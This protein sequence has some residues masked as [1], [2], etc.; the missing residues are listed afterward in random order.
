MAVALLLHVLGVVVWVGGMFFALVALRP[1]AMA[2]LQPPQLLPL[3]A[4]T[5][6][7]FLSWVAGTIIVI[8]G[9]GFYMIAA[10]GGFR[11]VGTHVHVMLAM[12]IL[13]ML[14]FVHIRVAPFRRLAGAVVSQSWPRAGAAMASIRKYIAVNLGL[15]LLTIAIAILGRAW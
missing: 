3:M 1:A 9:S 5:M 2:T 10:M 8:L 11:A 15:G 6:S 14:I 7:R 4:A 13:M 12:G